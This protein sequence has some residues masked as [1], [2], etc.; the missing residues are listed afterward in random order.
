MLEVLFEIFLPLSF[1]V[2]YESE[3]QR[4]SSSLHKWGFV[5]KQQPAQ[6]L[7]LAEVIMASL[8][9]FTRP[10]LCPFF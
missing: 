3:R 8:R 2:C 1:S 5:V 7:C 10:V 6:Y 4:I 9:C